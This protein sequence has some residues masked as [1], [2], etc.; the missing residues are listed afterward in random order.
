MH[1]PED[2]RDRVI[3]HPCSQAGFFHDANACHDRSY[4]AQVYRIE[5]VLRL[6]HHD[7]GI[8]GVISDG[9]YDDTRLSR[10][11]IAAMDALSRISSA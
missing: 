5:I 1:Q 11:W 6:T 10:L 9:V 2:T 4:P 8:C 3:E 7:A